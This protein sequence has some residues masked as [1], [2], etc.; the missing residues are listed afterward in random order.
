MS[1]DTLLAWLYATPIAT[2]VR[3][4]S[5]LFPTV[6]TVHVLAITLVVGSISIVDLRLLGVASR[7]RA[8]TEV[9]AEILPLTWCAFAVAVVSGSL[10]FSSQAI[11]Y[12][13]NLAFELKMALLLLAGL[14]MVVFH[15][16]TQRD[17]AAWDRA[18][19]PPLGP[20]LAGGI[21][22]ALWIAIVF[23]GR[24]IGFTMAQ[25]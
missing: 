12:V 22:L 17:I 20:R 11:K 9:T 16:L 2:A 24:V 8:V 5:F 13:D 21:S 1:L 14:N 18:E 6:E 7:G 23:C 15:Q 3:E 25:F 10:L 4:S 19:R